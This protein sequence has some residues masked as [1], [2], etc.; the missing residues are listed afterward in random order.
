[1]FPYYIVR[2]KHK[3]SPTAIAPA[4][5]FPYYIVRFKLDPPTEE[6]KEEI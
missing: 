3:Y 4:I 5:M 1:M 2:F 6:K